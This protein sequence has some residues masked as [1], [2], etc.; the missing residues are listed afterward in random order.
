M[1]AALLPDLKSFFGRSGYT[2]VS[3]Y[4]FVSAA[5]AKRVCE[6]RVSFPSI[7]LQGPPLQRSALPGREVMG[8]IEKKKVINL[9]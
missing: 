6:G 2:T 3:M 9:W 1:K 5:G 4:M 8:R 7:S